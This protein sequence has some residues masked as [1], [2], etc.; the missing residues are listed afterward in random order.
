MKFDQVYPARITSKQIPSYTRCY[1][2][3]STTLNANMIQQ[4]IGTQQQ[5]S[6][7]TSCPMTANSLIKY[8]DMDAENTTPA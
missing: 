1:V 7:V 5:V 8:F 6:S 4:L 2:L 3:M